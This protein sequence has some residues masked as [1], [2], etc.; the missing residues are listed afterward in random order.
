M[1]VQELRVADLC[2][3]CVRQWPLFASRSWRGF[4]LNSL[5][6]AKL[7]LFDNTNT[8]THDITLS[9]MSGYSSRRGYGS[10]RGNYYQTQNRDH[11]TSRPADERSQPGHPDH[12]LWMI[13]QARRDYDREEEENRGR[14][15]AEP[16]HNYGGNSHGHLQAQHRQQHLETQP[17]PVQGQ[18]PLPSGWTMHRDP[19]S[20]RNYFVDPTLH[21][22]WEAPAP[23]PPPP[24]PQS[25]APPL[26]YARSRQHNDRQRE[27]EIDAALRSQR[28]RDEPQRRRRLELLRERDREI[29]REIELEREQAQR[30]EAQRERERTQPQPRPRP[31]PQTLAPSQPQRRALPNLDFRTI[32]GEPQNIPLR[33]RQ[34]RDRSPQPQ[35]NGR[36]LP[37]RDGP[38]H[39]QGN[40]AG[41]DR[42]P[43]GR[44]QGNN[45]TRRAGS[46]AE[47]IDDMRIIRYVTPPP[48]S[49]QGQ[50]ASISQVR[51]WDLTQLPLRHGDEDLKVK[52]AQADARPTHDAHDKAR[53]KR[54]ISMDFFRKIAGR[55]TLSC[56][57]CHLS[58]EKCDGGLPCT[59]CK[60]KNRRCRVEFPQANAANAKHG[61]VPAELWKAIALAILRLG[62][63]EQ[64]VENV[65]KMLEWALPT[66]FFP[67]GRR[68]VHSKAILSPHLKGLALKKDVTSVFSC[69]KGHNPALADR[70][71]H[72]FLRAMNNLDLF[73]AELR[74]E[75]TTRTAATTTASTTAPTADSAS[76]AGG[77]SQDGADESSAH[78]AT[79]EEAG[80]SGS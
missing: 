13:E 39:P 54:V 74:A 61:T 4:V 59:T 56:G 33:P 37:R 20:G 51:H 31:R 19:R 47:E 65:R 58:L 52:L 76:Q 27:E 10:H 48:A 35:S 71:D 16:A 5:R 17:A 53:V 25:S 42:A 75:E 24:P 46:T 23:P 60:H 72:H 64:T 73:L 68:P 79:V 43:T 78:Q 22:H 62:Y 6:R 63:G 36:Q 28:Q 18:P 2:R 8:K 40:T 11:H 1:V 50:V 29:E 41:T 66:K 38:T 69:P 57:P 55:K 49:Q 44:R 15:L 3:I 7:H 21:S 80:D 70:E 12:Y 26:D 34:A 77:E 9:T 32:L 30:E 45:E 67:L 14:S